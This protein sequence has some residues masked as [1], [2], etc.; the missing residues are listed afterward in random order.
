MIV[1]QLYTRYQ[2]LQHASSFLQIS[3]LSLSEKTLLPDSFAYTPGDATVHHFTALVSKLDDTFA[4][5]L[6]LSNDG[7]VV[8]YFLLGKLPACGEPAWAGLLAVGIHT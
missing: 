6:D 3:P 2:Y 7:S 4:F 5:T 8:F 1:S